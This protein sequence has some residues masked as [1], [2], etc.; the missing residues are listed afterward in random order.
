MSDTVEEFKNCFAPIANSNSRILILGTLPGE[1][2]LAKNEYYGHSRNHFWPI[3]ADVLGE[4]LPVPY[5]ERVAMLLRNG[6]ALWDVLHS[7]QRVASALDSKIENPIAN[8]F[9]GFFT[10]HPQIRGLL[11]NGNNA[12]KFF[13]RLVAKTQNVPLSAEQMRTVP[14]TSP[15]YARPF[16]EK[17]VK[18]R[19]ALTAL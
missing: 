6:V 10:A 17:V 18:W 11:F 15:A 12:Q 3:I 5:E 9:A 14:S 16:E 7:A 2:S 4:N 1:V 8:D 19:E 13:R